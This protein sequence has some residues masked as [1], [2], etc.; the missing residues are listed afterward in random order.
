MVS[1]LFGFVLD[2]PAA[3]DSGEVEDGPVDPSDDEGTVFHAG[4]DEEHGSLV[5]DMFFVFKP[6]FYFPAEV[7]GMLRVAAEEA[8]NLVGVMDM[9]G[10]FER[11]VG[12]EVPCGVHVKGAF[13]NVFVHPE[14]AGGVF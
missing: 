5:D 8:D 10:V 7:V 4:G 12:F 11:G 14:D 3:G 1:L 13:H 6:D 2:V 9:G